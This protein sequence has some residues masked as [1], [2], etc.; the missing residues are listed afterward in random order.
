[1][2]WSYIACFVDTD[3]FLGIYKKYALIGFYNTHRK[4]LELMQDFLGCGKIYE[5][6]QKSHLVLNP[7]RYY[8]LRI[9]KKNDCQFV[10]ENI[11]DKMIIKKEKA[12]KVLEWLKKNPHYPK[13]KNGLYWCPRCKQY[14]PKSVFNK[15]HSR[16]YG[17][18][19]YCKK[20]I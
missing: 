15:N 16:K 1:M 9:Q 19:T 14:L 13:Q 7:R 11:L 5:K 10:L 18:G 4:C 8:C 17:I 2:D 6:K 12:S 20:C 3:G